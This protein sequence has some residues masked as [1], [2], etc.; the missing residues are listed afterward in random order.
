MEVGVHVWF[1]ME[2]GWTRGIIESVNE[3]ELQIK[4]QDELHSVNLTAKG[5]AERV[6]FAGE[7]EKDNSVSDLSTLQHA[8]EPSMLETLHSR[9]LSGQ[10]FTLA[11][12]TL[13]SVNPFQQ[14]ALF[15]REVMDQYTVEIGTRRTAPVVEPHLFQITM[16][17]VQ[18]MFRERGR[19]QTIVISGESGSGKSE[20]RAF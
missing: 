11:G 12:S 14:T 7:P 3:A 19:N 2:T 8:N 16:T 13:I 10:I 17:A 9:F 20:V 5:N 1:L 6:Q 4:I 15:T 18:R